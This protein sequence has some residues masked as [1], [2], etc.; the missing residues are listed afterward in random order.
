MALSSGAGSAQQ[1]V[2]AGQRRC[3]RHAKMPIYVSEK[4]SVALQT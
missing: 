1:E 2:I 4:G 3:A